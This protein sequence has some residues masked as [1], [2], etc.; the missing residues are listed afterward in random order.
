LA[1]LQL[2]LRLGQTS[3]I[4]A[5][6]KLPN[7]DIAVPCD[8]NEINQCV[9]A[10][11][12]D[13]EQAYKRC[14][15]AIDQA[16]MNAL[17]FLRKQLRSNSGVFMPGERAAGVLGLLAGSKAY[18]KVKKFDRLLK[19]KGGQLLANS[20]AI[21]FLTDMKHIE[22]EHPESSQPLEYLDYTSLIEYMGVVR[23]YCLDSKDYYGYD[24]F[25]E[26]QR[27]LKTEN[28]ALDGGLIL[29][30]CNTKLPI[31][32]ETLN[33]LINGTIKEPSSS[34]LYVPEI[35]LKLLATLCVEKKITRITGKSEMDL[36]AFKDHKQKLQELKSDLG[37]YLQQYFLETGGTFGGFI[38]TS[39]ATQP[40]NKIT[41][42]TELFLHSLPALINTQKDDG[43]F[44][45]SVPFTAIALPSISHIISSEFDEIECPRVT[46]R[47]WQDGSVKIILSYVMQDKVI[48]QQRTTGH[49]FV[50]NGAKLISA[51]KKHS[52]Q[53][54]H[55][56]KLK[57]IEGG[58]ITKIDSWN[59]IG[60]KDNLQAYWKVQKDLGNGNYDDITEKLDKETLFRDTKYMFSFV[61]NQ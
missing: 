41:S 25:H 2:T 32:N 33:K 15:N 55:T 52:E 27:R 9:K 10:D 28:D 29:A 61:Q 57:I 7:S 18:E 50:H 46:R 14:S 21:D 40:L 8:M 60:N 34:R 37:N 54:P 51:L 35:S 44:G 19:G 16:G 59:N 58:V 20:V 42:K 4:I 53:N 22:R 26:V 11:I 56:F 43:S 24:L 12:L 5:Q 48:S 31:D 13:N 45:G 47:K 17:K 49:L 1:Y 3:T 30:L 36:K 23:A 38:E 39:L 6:C